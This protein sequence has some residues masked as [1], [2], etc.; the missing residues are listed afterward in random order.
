[1][2]DTNIFRTVARQILDSRGNPTL[3]VDIWLESGIMGRASVPSGASTGSYEA[4]E[5]RD[6]EKPFGGLGVM[7]AINNINGIIAPKIVGVDVTK[8]MEIDMLLILLD[9][10]ENKSKLGA[11]ATLAVSLAVARAAAIA[12]ELPLYQ[13]LGGP[14]ATHLPLPLMNIL[15]GGRHA[16]NNLD[17][18]EFMIAPVGANS[19]AEALQMGS[20]VFHG[21][22]K[23]LKAKG[24]ITSVG[25]E[26]GF[27]PKLKSNEEALELIIDAIHEAGYKPEE[28]ICLALDCAASEF[29]KDGKYVFAKSTGESMTSEELIDIYEKLTEKYPV[30]SIEDGLAEDDWNGWKL[31]TEKLGKKIQIVG[32]D[33]FVTNIKRI[34]KGIHMKAANSVLI[35]LNQ[36]GTLSETLSAIE[37]AKRSSYTAVISHRSG[38]TDDSFIS[39]L[40]VATNAGQ[41]KTGSLCRMD[42]VA[43]YNELL[44]IEEDLRFAAQYYGKG[45]FYNLGL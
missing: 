18:Q 12:V 8:Q 35:K 26:G 17:F 25:D 44:R 31:L 6:G 13:Y 39:H 2:T 3:E 33:L 43:K 5:M 9:G 30:I 34:R 16:D 37:F 40:A 32:D 42:R 23:I 36:I 41:I 22:K 20:E 19:F 24:H 15:N 14:C 27:A 21:L 4:V 10:T 1:M 29:Y 45:V 28:E 11:N 7:K 38:E